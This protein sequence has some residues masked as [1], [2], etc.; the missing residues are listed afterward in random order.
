MKKIFILLTL[1]I[2]SACSERTLKEF[3]PEKPKSG[4]AIVYAYASPRTMG[5]IS[6]GVSDLK[7]SGKS[8]KN[9]YKKY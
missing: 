7:L 1:L 5:T 2:L 3:V 6:D 4:K 9:V 8:A